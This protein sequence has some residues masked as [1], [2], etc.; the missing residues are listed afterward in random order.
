MR[1]LLP[2]VFAALALAETP[3]PPHKIAGNLYYTGS[4]ENASYLVT[5]PQGH[6]LINP[7]FEE[8]VPLIEAAV[9]KLGFKFTD[10]K[11]L[12]T[13]HAHGDHIA[14]CAAAVEKSGARVM[15]MTGDE[16]IVRTGGDG[17]FQYTE[18]FKPCRVGRVLK[19]NDTVELGGSKLTARLTPGHT[20]GCTT[21]T[22]RVAEHGKELLAVIVGSPN[23]NPGY[24]LVNNDQYPSIAADFRKA[25][26]VWKSIPADL[27][28]GAHGAYYGL[29]EKY[30][31]L[32]RG[33][34]PFIDPQGYRNYIESKEKEFETKLAAQKEN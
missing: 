13:S 1:L 12:L 19:D 6:I 23:V 34:N 29:E 4:V 30:P 18:R 7:S 26:A 3:F 9:S 22:M 2:V 16:E 31:R 33:P 10:I 8:S 28:L 17:D 21:W 20:R 11:I 27:F 15:I 5:T 32:G 14:G 24:R 25:F